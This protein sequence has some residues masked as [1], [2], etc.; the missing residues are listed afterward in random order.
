M[1]TQWKVIGSGDQNSDVVT[2]L[3]NEGIGSQ[4]A[5]S[6][7]HDKTAFVVWG[8]DD[9]QTNKPGFVWK[10]LGQTSSNAAAQR[11]LQTA[12]ACGGAVSV[13]SQDVFVVWGYVED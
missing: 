8:N 9:N 11:L 10:T 2:L 5:V 12:A 13:N 1:T 7:N 4:A 6:V 3:N